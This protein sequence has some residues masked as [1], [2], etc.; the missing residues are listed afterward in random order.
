[1]TWSMPTM[2]CSR[3]A[4]G[5][6][7]LIVGLTT[8]TSEAQTKFNSG[9]NVQPVFEGWEKNP[10]GSFDFLFG[11]LNRNYR[12]RPHVPVGAN[13]HFSPGD[14]DRGQ[15]SHFYPRRQNYVFK[16]RVPA[17]FGDKDLVWTVTHAG[18][19]D[20][21]VGSLWPVWEVDEAVIKANRGMGI[22]GSYVDN[23]SPNIG[24]D[25]P[26]THAVSVGAAVTL[27]VVAGDDGIPGP[28]PEAAERRGNR[29]GRPGPDQQNILNPRAA[30]ARGLSVTW[31]QHRGPVP[32]SFSPM[33]PP[34]ENGRASTI[35]SFTAPGTYVLRAIA[36]DTV[37]TAA[38]DVTVVVAP[39]N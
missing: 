39:A 15:P 23:H 2:T 12:E 35:A 6:A 25:G 9:Q 10:D 20:T 22:S 19:S 1:M 36:D 17:D 5:L 13:N 21:A 27:V 7:L 34:L 37:L 28:N 33:M 38:V 3:L 24:L 29:R 16:V 11:Y 14:G 31:L 4:C 30:V 8:S 26:D 32:V 18:R